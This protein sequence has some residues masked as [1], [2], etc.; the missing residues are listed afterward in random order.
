MRSARLIV[1]R[2]SSCRAWQTRVENIA[3]SS[4]L[5]VRLDVAREA[6]VLYWYHN[7]TLTE[8]S[9]FPCPSHYDFRGHLA[10]VT[11]AARGI[12]E[13]IGAAL[14]GA[15]AAVYCFDIGA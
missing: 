11:G 9:T 3:T 2:C 13:S 8:M 4:A 15:G 7:T 10:V 14:A 1:S 6:K 5:G 12:G